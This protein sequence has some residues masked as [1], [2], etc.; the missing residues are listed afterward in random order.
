VSLDKGF[1]N[2]QAQTGRIIIG[3]LTRLVGPIE[4]IKYKGEVIRRDTVTGIAHF[5]LDAPLFG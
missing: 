2:G 5:Q 3:A 4:T 1:G